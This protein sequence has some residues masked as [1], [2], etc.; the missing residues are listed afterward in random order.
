MVT[1]YCQALMR[2]PT[3]LIEIWEMI[4]GAVRPKNSPE[5]SAAQFDR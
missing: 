3:D 2:I 5:F 1:G 4:K